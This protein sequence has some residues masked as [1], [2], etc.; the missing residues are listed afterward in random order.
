VLVAGAS[1]VACA[2]DG[3]RPSVEVFGPATVVDPL[4]ADFRFDISYYD[5]RT[6]ICPVEQ[7]TFTDLSGGSPTAWFWR[8]PDGTTSDRQHPIV[9]GHLYGDVELTITRGDAS[10]RISHE[11]VPRDC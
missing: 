7:I 3:P 1:L 8:F 5:T 4:R 11:L 9:S 2:P 10:D 6:T